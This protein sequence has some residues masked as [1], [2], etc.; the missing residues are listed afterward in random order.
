[1]DITAKW[2]KH[3]ILEEYHQSHRRPKSDDFQE[4]FG[5]FFG[6]QKSIF[7]NQVCLEIGCGITG[8]IHYLDNAKIT[9]GLDPLC[10]TCKDLYVQEKTQETPHLMAVGE[11]LPIQDDSIDSVF[12]IGVLDHCIEPSLVVKEMSRV[13]KQCGKAYIRVY[14]FEL[15]K[16]IR[17]KLTIFDPHPHHLSQH[18]VL[19]WI[20]ENNLQMYKLK[21]DKV[22]FSGAWTRLKT[23][24]VNSAIKY[25]GATILGIEELALIVE[26]K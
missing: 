22:P 13:L 7:D 3:Q 15:P 16:W 4:Y 19:S 11:Y 20:Y 10:L 8:A 14:T 2:N 21:S 17:D 5:D 24:T 23:G 26:K 18:E 6:V 12:I 1:M 9:I 25:V